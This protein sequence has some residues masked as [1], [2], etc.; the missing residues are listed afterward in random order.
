ML[1]RITS[2]VVFPLL[3]LNRKNFKNTDYALPAFLL[4]GIYSCLIYHWQDNYPTEFIRHRMFLFIPFSYI[5]AY[6][7]KSIFS[8]SGKKAKKLAIFFIAAALAYSVLNI[9]ALF[10][11]DSKFS[12]NRD[13][14]EIKILME[15]QKMF[16]DK[17]KISTLFSL[18]PYDDVNLKKYFFAN[19]FNK[20]KSK[21]SPV[22]IY[23][24]LE[25]LRSFIS[26]SEKESMKKI[27]FP[28]LVWGDDNNMIRPGFYKAKRNFDMSTSRHYYI[29]K[30]GI[31]AMLSGNY[32][33]AYE[34]FGR[35]AENECSGKCF[36]VYKMIAASAARDYEKAKIESEAVMNENHSFYEWGKIT[37]KHI[38]IA[39]SQAAE[40]GGI[41]LK[42]AATHCLHYDI[43]FCE[44]MLWD[45]ISNPLE[46]KSK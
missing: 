20:G 23:I 11:I 45:Y 26:E 38:N 9:R 27:L 7:I 18:P 41:K 44:R 1:R 17:Y 42:Q 15:G 32:D 36:H 46:I 30:L 14:T 29:V 6:S 34:L 16:A 21:N 43:R 8:F 4:A 33:K 13:R 10:I 37:E 35:A 19:Y 5:S 3:C 24:S 22:L 2:E 12:E 25:D 40:E 31:A 28:M 39:M